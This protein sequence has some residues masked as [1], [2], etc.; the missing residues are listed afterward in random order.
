MSIKI[1]NLR[2]TVTSMLLTLLSLI[3]LSS[4][5]KYLDEKSDNS[6]VIPETLTDL[7]GI[8][9]DNESMNS[10]TPGFGESSADDV[11][12]RGDVFN[13]FGDLD[14]KVYTWQVEIYNY[15]NDWAFSYI[16]IYNSNYCL[17]K[18]ELINQTA[19]N[20]DQW[21]NIKGSAL[22]F[23]GYY[24][25]NLIWEY[26]KAYNENTADTDLGIIIRLNSNFNIPSQRASVR[27]SYMQAIKD[28]LNAS[29]YLPDRPM[30]VMR[31]S[32]GACYGALARAYLSMR[33]YDS[34]YKYAELCLGI[35]NDIKNYNDPD[36]STGNV[37]FQPF[38]KEIIFYSTQSQ[39]YTCK[40]PIYGS[41]D[42][43]LFSS[44]D[45][46]D[47]RKSVFFRLFNGYQRFK[48]NYSAQSNV[49]FSGI[50]C[51]EILLIKAECLARK[52][53]INQ[54]MA[55]LNNLLINRFLTGTFTPI[56]VSDQME[57]LTIILKERRKELL[58]RGLRWADIKR[59]NVENWNI[60]PKR[61]ANNQVFELEPN[62]KKYALPIPND[63]II[64]TGIEQN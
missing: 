44:Y 6:L 63:I 64:S 31:P 42:S 59:L 3:M 50:A 62:S 26:S 4:C 40:S 12:V 53:E 30:H 34:A 51:D 52:G 61:I 32:K 56:T 47:R 7:Q 49:L 60:V 43:T 25:L 24:F 10:N 35:K 22:F 58:M 17:E 2:D 21:N 13:T 57:A 9:D 33:N 27:D 1:I 48:G 54:A 38:N 37:S 28:L 11:F 39:N 55:E 5:E 15:P 23:R 20:R 14:K 16:P 29:Y 45:N 46:N 36:I 8:M 41:I 18:I 19:S